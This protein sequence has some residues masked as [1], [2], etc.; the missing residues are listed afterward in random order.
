[1]GP[2]RVALRGEERAPTFAQLSAARPPEYGPEPPS[3]A[4][5]AATLS[6]TEAEVG[7]GGMRPAGVSC[8]LPFL[9][10][11]L[12]DRAAVSRARLDTAR[13]RA[14]IAGW[15]SPHIFLFAP[16]GDS[17]RADFRA[18]MFGPASGIEEDPATGSAAAALA[19]Y[20]GALDDAP[21]GRLRWVV[22]QGVEM[23]RPSVLHLE[24]DKAEGRV[25]AVRVG[26]SAVCVSEGTM[27]IPSV[28]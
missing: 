7:A 9:L 19:G 22:E 4:A 21:A 1:V 23:G 14:E 17:P 5:I 24:A 15:W 10:V 27:S 13:W 16:D 11:P 25:V 12:R 2:V 3:D 18:R 20:L 8:G 6:L 28:D 26:G